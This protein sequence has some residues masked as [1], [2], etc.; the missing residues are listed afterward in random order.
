MHSSVLLWHNFPLEKKVEICGKTDVHSCLQKTLLFLLFKGT[1][2]GNANKSV[3]VILLKSFL[4]RRLLIE[5]LECLFIK[6]L[7]S[8][9]STL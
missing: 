2:Q 1:N 6:K 3:F 8:F 7:L 9:L 4:N 5:D